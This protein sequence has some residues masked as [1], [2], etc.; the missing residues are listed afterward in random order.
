M[1]IH[2]AT[3]LALSFAAF[4]FAKVKKMDEG[5]DDMKEIASAIRLGSNTFINYEYRV[6]Y[7]VV[8]VVAVIMAIAT[9]WHAAVALIIGSIMSG[10]AGMIGMKIAT[11]ANVFPIN[12]QTR[13]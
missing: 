13:T 10:S 8:L 3:V 12:P 6:L 9:S 1:F 5:T 2:F 11:Y 4:N 7:T